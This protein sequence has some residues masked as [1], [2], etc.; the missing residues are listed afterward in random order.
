MVNYFRQCSSVVEQR[1]HKPLVAGSNPA[2]A[3]NKYKQTSAEQRTSLV[4]LLIHVFVTLRP[5]DGGDSL[6]LQRLLG[7]TTLMMTN[8]YCQAVGCCDAIESHK[9][10]SLVDRLIH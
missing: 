6:M 1:T 9:R 4:S 7:H 2:A 3:T 10:Y 5:N 8:Q